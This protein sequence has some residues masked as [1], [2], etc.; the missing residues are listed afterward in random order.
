MRFVAV[1]AGGTYSYRCACVRTVTTGLPGVA[2]PC[3]HCSSYTFL[4]CRL[5]GGEVVLRNEMDWVRFHYCA[6]IP[7]P[8]AVVPTISAVKQFPLAPFQQTT[9]SGYLLCAVMLRV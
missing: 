8:S 6:L 7:V 2:A 4:C 5:T 9:S 1:E 3:G